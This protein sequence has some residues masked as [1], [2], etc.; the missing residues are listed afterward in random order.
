MLSSGAVALAF[1]GALVERLQDGREPAAI[2]ASA[3]APVDAPAEGSTEVVA[4]V[5][6]YDLAAAGVTEPGKG[7]NAK[8][9]AL[10]EKHRWR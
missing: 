8:V 6:P 7:I 3:D 10:A 4:P 2:D 9:L 5:G 1:G